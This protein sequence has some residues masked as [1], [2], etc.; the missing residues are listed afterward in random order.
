MVITR[1]S[2]LFKADAPAF[3]NHLKT[4]GHYCEQVSQLP[5]FTLSVQGEIQA[6]H[7]LVFTSSAQISNI[8]FWLSTSLQ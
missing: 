6:A 1:R 4:F 8:F 2:N 3:E 5:Y 7:E